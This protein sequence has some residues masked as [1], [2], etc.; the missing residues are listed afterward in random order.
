MPDVPST[1]DDEIDL[2]SL[3][4]TIWEGKW[5][6]ASIVAVS[7]LSVFGFNI[8]K[9]NT[10]FTATTEIRPIASFEFDKY[11]LFNSSLKIIEKVEKEKEKEKDKD[12]DKDKEQ[13]E[14]RNI[15]VQF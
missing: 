5:K 11:S 4:Q 3:I 8:V 15:Y 2:L 7:L 10:T 12:K 14:K 9:P 6:I 1:Y 13:K